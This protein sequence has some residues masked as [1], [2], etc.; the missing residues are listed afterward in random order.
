MVLSKITSLP[1][2]SDQ[3][4]DPLARDV[5]SSLGTATQTISETTDQITEKSQVTVGSGN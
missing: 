5:L 1:G 4:N 2:V 3:I